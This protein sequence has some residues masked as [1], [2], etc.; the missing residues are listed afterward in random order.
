MFVFSYIR[1]VFLNAL[2]IHVFMFPADLL[3]ARGSIARAAKRRQCASARDSRRRR[4]QPE[5]ARKLE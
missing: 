2:V 1:R 3:V 5:P 4:R